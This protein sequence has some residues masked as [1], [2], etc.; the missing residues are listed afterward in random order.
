MTAQEAVRTW[1]VGQDGAR[2]DDGGPHTACCAVQMAPPRGPPSLE[3]GSAV[4][5]A[6]DTALAD[7]AVTR[8]R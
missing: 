3:A 4:I 2:A 7:I 5:A 6:H 1:L 8:S